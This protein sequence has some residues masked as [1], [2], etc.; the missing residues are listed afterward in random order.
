MFRTYLECREAALV[1]PSLHASTCA[2]LAAVDDTCG[3]DIE[4]AIMVISAA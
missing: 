3:L 4:K 2:P 1:L